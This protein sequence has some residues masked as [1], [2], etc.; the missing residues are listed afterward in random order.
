MRDRGIQLT[1][2]DG[3]KISE[4]EKFLKFVIEFEDFDLELAG[5]A[6]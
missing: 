6:N 3:S 4:E 2:E 1:K 5:I